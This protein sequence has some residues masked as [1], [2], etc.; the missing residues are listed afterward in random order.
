MEIVNRNIE[1]NIETLAAIALMYAPDK[2]LKELWNST[3]IQ[4]ALKAKG[5]SEAEIT[6]RYDAIMAEF[7]ALQGNSEQ[8]VCRCVNSFR[9]TNRRQNKGGIMERQSIWGAKE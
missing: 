5:W 1:D 2:S 8:T 3:N 6:Q 4:G 9:F 7:E